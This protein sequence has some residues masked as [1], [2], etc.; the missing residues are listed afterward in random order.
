M[1]AD[2]VGSLTVLSRYS[3]KKARPTLRKAPSRMPIAM[4][5]TGCGRIG[6][7]GTVAG[8]TMRMLVDLSSAATSVSF[9]RDVRLSRT[10]LA[11]S[12]SF[13]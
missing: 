6:P 2:V 4:S 9:E 1:L 11:A 10:C 5:R 7:L 13:F 8:S 12:S 3:R